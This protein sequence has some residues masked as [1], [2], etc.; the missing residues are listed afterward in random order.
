MCRRGDTVRLQRFKRQKPDTIISY[1]Y[2]MVQNNT[3]ISESNYFWRKS[4]NAR[5]KGDNS[6]ISKPT[7]LIPYRPVVPNPQSSD[8]SC[9]KGKFFK[10][11]NWDWQAE[12]NKMLLVAHYLV[13]VSIV[14]GQWPW[15]RLVLLI[16]IPSS[17]SFQPL[18]RRDLVVHEA[19]SKWPGE[20]TPTGR[21]AV[22]E[23]NGRGWKSEM[24]W[25][26]LPYG[27]KLI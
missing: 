9:G 19:T 23:K 25:K 10:S 27:K 26:I 17:S 4:E 13:R 15:E 7:L 2:L 3:K 22:S 5:D 24:D 6:L 12:Q 16:H 21:S 20:V 1:Q 11:W 18:A 8:V 14:P